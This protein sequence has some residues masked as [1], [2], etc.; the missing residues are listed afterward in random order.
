MKRSYLSTVSLS[1]PCVARSALGASWA[2]LY[3]S[4]ETWMMAECES[5]V[6]ASFVAQVRGGMFYGLQVH[7]ARLA[8][9]AV[10]IR[11]PDNLCD[12]NYLD[13]RVAYCSC[14]VI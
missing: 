14:W 12:N 3:L 13:V 6:L 2:S 1:S 4:S 8:E 7:R 5:V 11:R 10:L 9:R